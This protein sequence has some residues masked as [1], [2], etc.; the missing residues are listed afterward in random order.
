MMF[1]FS[2][3]TDEESSGT[4]VDSPEEDKEDEGKRKLHMKKCYCFIHVQVQTELINESCK[5]FIDN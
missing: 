3:W 5:G 2:D 4:D 1:V